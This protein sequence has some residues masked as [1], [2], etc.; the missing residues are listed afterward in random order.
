MK[1]KIT[2][3]Y[4]G[5]A[6]MGSQ[7]QHSTPHTVMGTFQKILQGLGIDDTAVA[8]GRTDR[9]V[10]AVGQV[11]HVKLP[12]YWS[13]LQRLRH[14]LNIRLP[15]TLHV[16]SIYP[17]SNNFHARYSAKKRIYRYIISSGE[18]NPFL[19][20][21]VSFVETIDLDAINHAMQLFVG[22]HDFQYFMKQGSDTQ[23]SMREI[24]RA[25]AY[26]HNTFN[27]LYF[28]ANGYLRSQIR[29]MV[30]FLL[31]ISDQTRTPQQLQEQ[32]SC[33]HIYSRRLAPPNGL[34]L[35]KIKY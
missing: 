26:R 7:S 32:L 18:S 5:S 12:D 8:S 14:T 23:S 24:Y 16:R 11:L 29:L 15:H 9:N 28:E 3:S 22:E 6:F 27:V 35:A 25:F 1:V 10:H 2:L 33:K 34:Y 21:Y 20:R 31:Q 13:D 30:G 19:Q 17:V 4:D